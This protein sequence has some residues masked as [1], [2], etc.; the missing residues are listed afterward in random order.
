MLMAG[1]EFTTGEHQLKLFQK[2]RKRLIE[3]AQIRVAE[4][5]GDA[6]AVVQVMQPVA[7]LHR[8]SAKTGCD[9]A[10]KPPPVQQYRSC[11]VVFYSTILHSLNLS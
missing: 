7:L 8:A 6:G 10:F 2:Q 5:P 3:M 4:P 9:I 11:L 1:I